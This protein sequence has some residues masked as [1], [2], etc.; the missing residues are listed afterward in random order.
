MHIDSTSDTIQLQES[1]PE[2]ESGRNQSSEEP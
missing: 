1:A 2:Q